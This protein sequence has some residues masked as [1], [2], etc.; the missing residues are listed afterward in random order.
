MVLNLINFIQVAIVWI[1]IIPELLFAIHKEKRE[2]KKP[3]AASVTE[4]FGR[5]ASM[6]LM[7][8]PLG[9]WEFGFASSEEMIIY[10]AGNGILLAVY[11][12]LWVLFFKKQSFGKA[13]ALAIINIAVFLLCGILLRHWFLVVFAVIFAIGHLAVT[14]NKFKEA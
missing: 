14:V 10:F 12:L 2:N 1:L 3:D 13:M 6:L 4:Q 9:I 11:I 7:V 8:L 5:Y